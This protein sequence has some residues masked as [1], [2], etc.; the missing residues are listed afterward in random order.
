[1]GGLVITRTTE[2]CLAVVR[3][4]TQAIMESEREVPCCLSLENKTKVT[5]KKASSGLR[6]DKAWRWTI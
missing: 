2:T 5:E 3:G 4:V 6:F 1:M